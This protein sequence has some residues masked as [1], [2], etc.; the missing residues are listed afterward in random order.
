MWLRNAGL[1]SQ[2]VTSIALTG[3]SRRVD[4]VPTF[5]K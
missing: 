1:V 4:V 2:F 3:Q 5:G